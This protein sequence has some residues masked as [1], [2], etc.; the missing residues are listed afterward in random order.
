MSGRKS[1]KQARR[2]FHGK[3][4]EIDPKNDGFPLKSPPKG[5]K[6]AIKSRHFEFFREKVWQYR[7][8][9]IPLHS[10]NETR[11]LVSSPFSDFL[12]N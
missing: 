12:G 3:T 2:S 5:G 11:V 8:K 7:G 4:I 6:I 9:A 1:R 10:L